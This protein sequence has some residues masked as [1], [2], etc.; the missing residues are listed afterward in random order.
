MRLT[1]LS[2]LIFCLLAASPA[3]GQDPGR[4]I[5][6]RVS[7]V[8]FE[9]NGDIPG[10]YGCTGANVNPPLRIDG[11]PSGSKSL[12]LVFD[13]VDAPRGSYVH[14]ILWNIDPNTAEIRENS[15]PAGSVEGTNDFKKTTYGGPC[16]PTRPHTYVFRAYALDRNLDLPVTSTKKDLERAM[17]GHILAKA[18]LRGRYRKGPP[19]KK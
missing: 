6:M 8:A 4:Q 17:E 9:N 7:S 3:I 11:V 12:A 5:A 16:P 2:C 18:E 14:W 10:Q 15:V 1:F 19:S 13:D